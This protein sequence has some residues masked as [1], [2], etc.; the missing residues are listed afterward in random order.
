MNISVQKAF[1]ALLIYLSN[2]CFA[3]TFSVALFQGANPPYT[4]IKNGQHSGFFVDLFSKL[5]QLT[6]YDFVFR[7]YPAAR[8][9][10]EFD[11]GNVDIEPGVNEAWRQQRRIEGKFS[12]AY[13]YS[14]EVMVFKKKNAI[15]IKSVKDLH[16]KVVGTVRGYS[17]PKF[18]QAFNNKKI[19]KINNRSEELL[20]KQLQA[21]RLEYIFIGERTIKYYMQQNPQYRDFVIGDIVSKVEVKIR[22]H[23]SKAYILDK[24]NAALKILVAR[25]EIE[26]MYAKYELEKQQ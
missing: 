10:E 21:D 13:G 19:T 8:A 4:I 22:V 15:N 20:L 7:D 11:L 26:K 24:I 17:Y 14:T 16:G 12:I 9:L 2:T 25:G 6:N 18:E 1:L 23:P 5:S 3:E